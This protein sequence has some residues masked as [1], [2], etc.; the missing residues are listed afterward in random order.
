MCGCSPTAHAEEPVNFI[1]NPPALRAQCDRIFDLFQSDALMILLDPNGRWLFRRGSTRAIEAEFN[2][3]EI[4]FGQ[5]IV[6]GEAAIRQTLNSCRPGTNFLSFR[7]NC[8]SSRTFVVV[9]SE[10]L[11]LVVINRGDLQEGP[12]FDQTFKQICD[13]IRA[14]L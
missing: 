8:L 1:S 3:R 14:A 12:D 9:L 4:A 10:T 5:A 7:L 6:H 11:R 2:G 13:L